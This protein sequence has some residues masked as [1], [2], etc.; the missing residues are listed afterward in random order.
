MQ[1][2][3]P[4]NLTREEMLDYTREWTGERFDD[5]RPKISDSM[6]E[7]A[8][9]VSITGA[10]GVLRGEGYHHQYEGGWMC[11]H[12]GRGAGRPRADRHVHAAPP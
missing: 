1:K 2:F 10:W 8:R 5:G 7:R 3:C 4:F 9:A 6:I 11:T 12:P